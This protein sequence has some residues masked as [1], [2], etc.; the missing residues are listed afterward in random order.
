MRALAD[1]LHAAF[2]DPGT[3]VF[4]VVQTIVWALIV[5]SI[6][7][8]VVEALLPDGLRRA[9]GRSRKSPRRRG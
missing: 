3:T 2:H 9:R 8:L 1:K 7:L 5:L 6:L 4:R